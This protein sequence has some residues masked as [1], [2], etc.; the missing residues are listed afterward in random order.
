MIGR[1]RQN[2]S[3]IRWAEMNGLEREAEAKLG[4]QDATEEAIENRGVQTRRRLMRL[5]REEDKRT[6]PKG[7]LY[8]SQGTEQSTTEAKTDARLGLE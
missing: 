6:M 1:G 2:C 7:D 8:N 5:E 4:G 3:E